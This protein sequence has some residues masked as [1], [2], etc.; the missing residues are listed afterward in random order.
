MPSVP[1]VMMRSMFGLGLPVAEPWAYQHTL[2]VSL[3]DVE[4]WWKQSLPT[5]KKDLTNVAGNLPG[6][7]PTQPPPGLLMSAPQPSSGPDTTTIL[8]AVL[9]LGGAAGG[10]YY[11]QK[12][13]KK[14]GKAAK[15]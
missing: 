5:L 4:S 3:K 14:N 1:G 13:K 8:V 6:Q 15:A 11:W 12:S 10:Y 9:L 7:T 2:G